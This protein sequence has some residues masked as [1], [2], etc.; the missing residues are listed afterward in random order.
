MEGNKLKLTNSKK[1]LKTTGKYAYVLRL[2]ITQN[3]DAI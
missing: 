2:N 1:C 3:S